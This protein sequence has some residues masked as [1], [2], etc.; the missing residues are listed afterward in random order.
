MFYSSGLDNCGLHFCFQIFFRAGTLAQLEDARDEKTTG[1]IVELQAFCRGF[2]ARRNY[3]KLQVRFLD[4]L[5][6]RL[7]ENPS[8]LVENPSSFFN[9]PSLFLLDFFASV[10]PFQGRWSSL[11]GS[12]YVPKLVRVKSEMFPS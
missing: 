5:S 8:S 7:V 11:F 3:K 2:I 10:L 4:Q 1:T 9:P 12:F 6:G